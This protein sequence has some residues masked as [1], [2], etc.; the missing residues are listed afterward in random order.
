MQESNSEEKSLRRQDEISENHPGEKPRS[1]REKSVDSAVSG[2]SKQSVNI[3]KRSLSI[4]KKDENNL[5]ESL[6]TKEQEKKTTHYREKQ[7]KSN[8]GE[9]LKHIEENVHESVL[10]RPHEAD[11]EKKL[12]GQKY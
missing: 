3:S 11:E 12:S 5:L 10:E 7:S 1:R 6:I 4:S 2:D 8:V 9:S